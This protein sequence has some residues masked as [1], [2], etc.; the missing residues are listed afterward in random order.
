MFFYANKRVFS[1]KKFQFHIYIRGM[2]K[3]LINFE[4]LITFLV[5]FQIGRFVYFAAFNLR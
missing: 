3:F 2:Y 1:I 5:I 4:N